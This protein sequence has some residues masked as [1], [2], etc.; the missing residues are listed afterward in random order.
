MYTKKYGMQITDQ[1][2]NNTPNL[3]KHTQYILSVRVHNTNVLKSNSEILLHRNLQSERVHFQQSLKTGGQRKST[4]LP[5]NQLYGI[6]DEDNNYIVQKG[7]VIHCGRYVIESQI[8]SGSFGRVSDVGC[9]WSTH[10]H[11]CRW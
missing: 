9:A 6:D 7:A 8:G 5:Y 2:A 4:M 10:E 1:L 3:H 11:F